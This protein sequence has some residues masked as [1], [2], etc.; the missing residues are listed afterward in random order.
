MQTLPNQW[1][2]LETPGGE[3]GVVSKAKVFKRKHEA[4]LEFSEWLR[5]GGG[6]VGYTKKEGYFLLG[7]K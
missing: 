5:G 7:G 1:G 4:S 3:V 2:S 6:G